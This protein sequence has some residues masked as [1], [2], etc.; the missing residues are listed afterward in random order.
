MIAQNSTSHRMSQGK[1][2]SYTSQTSRTNAKC[3]E[4]PL[5]CKQIQKKKIISQKFQI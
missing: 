1:L 2:S 3:I 4:A 5:F